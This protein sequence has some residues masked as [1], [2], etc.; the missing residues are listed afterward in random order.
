MAIH[1]LSPI[2]CKNATCEGVSI[3]KLADGGG[4][5]L[6]VYNDGKKY[7]R[8]RYWNSGKENLLSLGVYPTV[9]L[10]DAREAA[11][12]LR[13]KNAN[14]LDPSADRKSEKINKKTSVENSFM[15][16]ADSWIVK[17]SN[18]WSSKHLIDVRRRLEKNIY[19][20]LAKRPINEITAPELL[21]VIQEIENRSAFDLAH[22]VMNVCG[23]VFRFGVATGKCL[24][25]PSSDLRGA[26]TPHKANHQNAVNIKELP[27]LLVDISNYENIGDKQTRIG[28]QLL[29]HTFVRTSELINAK[30][31]ELDIENA[32]WII[33]KERMKMKREHVVPL[34]VHVIDLLSQLKELS[35]SSLFLFPG[36]SSR[37]PISNNTLLFALYNLGYKGKMTGHGF[38][39]VAS[40]VLNDANF[41][42]DVIEKQ[43]AHC[44]VNEVR[45]AYNRAEYMKD[46]VAMMGWWSQYLVDLES[47]KA[48]NTITGR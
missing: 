11:E 31:S 14:N 40:T 47:G 41:N 10:K 24:R 48:I 36:R 13:K 15:S 16:V 45:A 22:R 5:Y 34:T 7:W 20:R 28:L 43:L 8:F 46:R 29:A 21:S 17:Q 44:E 39:A 25:D 4:L 3:R 18:A 37:K 23:Q 1:K 2:V 19:P 6:W 26:L 32:I 27:Q 42:K 30:W 33:P 35:G 12:V 38:R 9:S